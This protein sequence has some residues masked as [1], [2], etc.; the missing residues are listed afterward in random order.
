MCN[1]IHEEHEKI[2]EKGVGWKIF[3][4]RSIG[5]K[6]VWGFATKYQ[7]DKDKS[8]WITW[9]VPFSSYGD[10]FCFFVSYKEAVRAKKAAAFS[11]NAMIKKIEYEGGLC[12]QKENRFLDGEFEIALCKR[13]RV[14]EKKD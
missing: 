13:F 14:K 2:P 6:P 5:L 12:K 9:N 11:E 4:K 10:G 3:D 8:G 7:F 1:S